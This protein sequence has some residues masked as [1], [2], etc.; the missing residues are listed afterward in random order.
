MD[1]A[2]AVALATR[3]ARAAGDLLNDGSGAEIAQSQRGQGK[4]A[5]LSVHVGVGCGQIAG[6]HVGGLLKRWEYF[7]MGEVSRQRGRGV[8]RRE[9]S[10]LE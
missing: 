8:R 7:V 3:C 10:F 2:R 6:F 5:K 1:K 4:S 9:R